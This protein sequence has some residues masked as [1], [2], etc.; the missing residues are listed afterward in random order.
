ML[1]SLSQEQAVT[2]LV[3]RIV[4]ELQRAGAG[5]F[6]LSAPWFAHLSQFV[7]LS[8]PR[9]VTINIKALCILPSSNKQ[10][11]A[12]TILNLKVSLKYRRTELNEKKS[13]E[14]GGLNG[15]KV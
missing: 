15:G 3:S 11:T 10:K 6:P 9:R 4:C 14:R 8:P 1:T 13:G 12:F 7:L 5:P 2:I